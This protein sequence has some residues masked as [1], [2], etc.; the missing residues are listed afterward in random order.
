M[1]RAREA[2]AEDEDDEGRMARYVGSRSRRRHRAVPDV[3]DESDDDEYN[4]ASG[5]K[6]ASLEKQLETLRKQMKM[7]AQAQQ[8]GA[9]MAGFDFSGLYIAC[10]K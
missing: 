8:L 9:Q 7:M 10:A 6:L 4:D 5:A 1:Q 2:L 3:D